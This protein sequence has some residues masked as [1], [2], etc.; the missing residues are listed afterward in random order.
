MPVADDAGIDAKRLSN[1]S[2]ATKVVYQFP[3]FHVQGNITVRDNQSTR[4]SKNRFAAKLFRFPLV[5]STET[6]S[7]MGKRLRAARYAVGES[8][9]TQLCQKLNWE[10]NAWA[11]WESGKNRLDPLVLARFIE[12]FPALSSDYVLLGDYRRLSFEVVG[13][14]R[15]AEQ[16]VRDE[17]AAPVKRGR[18]RREAAALT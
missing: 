13:A 18:P 1:R 11:Q 8:N 2:H 15:Q 9:L 5:G 14:I 10:Q 7:F 16:R 3:P 12:M 17:E 4:K 6:M